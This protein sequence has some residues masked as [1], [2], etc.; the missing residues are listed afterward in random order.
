L[1]GSTEE[2]G[3]RERRPL[4]LLALLLAL[5][6]A[7][8]FFAR[9]NAKPGLVLVVVFD[10]LRADHLSQYGYPLATSPGLERLR[11]RATLFRNVYAPASYT[12]ASTASLM[13]GLSPA[14][15]GARLQGAKLL[16]ERLT[17]AELLS[18]RGYRTRGVSFNPVVA[19]VSGFTQGFDDF[20]EREQGTPFNLYPDI[21][22]GLRVIR[23][24]LAESDAPAFVYFQPMNTHGP[25]LVPPDARET[26]LGHRPEPSF[27][28][29]DPLMASILA[30]DVARR[31]EVTPEYVR[32]GIERYDTAIRYA[33]D[34]L[35]AFLAELERAG[36]FDDAL[37]VVT[38]DHGEEFFEH[39]G[40]SHGYS[41]HEEAVRVPLIVKLPGQRDARTVDARVTL[42]DV[43]PTL[44]E[45]VG[46]R[47]DSPVDGASLVP[48]IEG[49]AAAAPRRASLDLMADFAPRLVARARIEGH[50]KIVR[51]EQSYDGVRG[52]LR[53]YDLA[54]DPG[55]QRDLAAEQPERAAELAA[56]LEQPSGTAAP[57]ARAELADGL[58]AERLRALGYAR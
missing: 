26:L 8:I 1:R 12:T 22:D 40:F 24:W 33:T 21:S 19:H 38:A 9:A 3:V 35:G 42:M 15:H 14:A 56:R 46:A 31:R 47:L 57:A 36:R 54:A 58:D 23:R 41:L 49:D 16:P 34:A 53:L 39:G 11:A 52:R 45:V 28:Y 17:L 2:Q 5:V 43:L 44:A 37:V 48:L 13:T 6:P 51:V 20:V 18:A 25:Y 32:G 55:E 50:E 29:Y 7:W 27:R 10:A 30:G 4:L